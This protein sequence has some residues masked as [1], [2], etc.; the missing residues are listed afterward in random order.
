MDK[1]KYLFQVK[2]CLKKSEIALETSGKTRY[3][4]G[5]MSYFNPCGALRSRKK[6]GREGG[7]K[8][9][10]R[11]GGRKNGERKEIRDGR[12]AVR[13]RE[14]RWWEERKKRGRKERNGWK[15]EGGRG[16]GKKGGRKEGGK[17]ERK[18]G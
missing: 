10:R 8:G 4:S 14:N 18:K 17:Q 13:K 6:G 15:K 11:K 7:R 9:E 3:F 16:G 5:Y 1:C 12:K 2:I